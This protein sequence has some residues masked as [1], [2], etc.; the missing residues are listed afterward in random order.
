MACLVRIPLRVGY[1]T[2][3]WLSLRLS[4]SSNDYVYGTSSGSGGGSSGGSG[5]RTGGGATT[6]AEVVADPGGTQKRWQRGRGQ[7]AGAGAEA[8]VSSY[9]RIS[10]LLPAG[11]RPNTAQSGEKCCY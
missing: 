6:V 7:Q 1:E 3:L 5:G 10:L 2:S 11:F 8:E 4:S 9:G